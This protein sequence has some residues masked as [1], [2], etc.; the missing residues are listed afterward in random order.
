MSD[1][2]KAGEK[3]LLELFYNGAPAFSVREYAEVELRLTNQSSETLEDCTLQL[4]GTNVRSNLNLRPGATWSLPFKIGDL[5]G[6]L[7]FTA[8]T[9]G[10]STGGAVSYKTGET[11]TGEAVS[12]KTGETSTGEAV[13]YKTGE[14]ST[15]GAVSYK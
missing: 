3:L 8:S 5:V 4:G 6:E 13:S 11:S 14:T 9:G 7:Y 1:P 10:A 2:S 12:Y 15:G